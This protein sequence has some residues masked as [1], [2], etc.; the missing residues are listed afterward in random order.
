MTRKKEK[1]I[2]TEEKAGIVYS[3]QVSVSVKSGNKTISK[4][5]YHNMGGVAL[6]KFLANCIKDGGGQNSSL[7]PIKVKLFKVDT[8]KRASPNDIISELNKTENYGESV[9][10]EDRN[11]DIYSASVFV[12]KSDTANVASD[13]KAVTISFRM[14]YSY[15]TETKVNMIALYGRGITH[16]GYWSAYYLLAQKN[17]DGSVSWD[18]LEINSSQNYNLLIEWKM[19]FDNS[20]N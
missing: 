15:I 10:L 2:T 13:G 9:N 18:D 8:D 14:P 5:T 11:I 12:A 20:S 16:T 1:K 4:K 19:S 3:G 17:S 6:F 7:L